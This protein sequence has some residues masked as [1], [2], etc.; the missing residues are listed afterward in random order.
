MRTDFR[1]W[2]YYYARFEN[3]T[4]TTTKITRDSQN[5]HQAIPFNLPSSSSHLSS[6]YPSISRHFQ[7]FLAIS[8]PVQPI[9]ALTSLLK[10]CAVIFFGHFKPFSAIS[11][12]L[13]LSLANSSPSQPFLKRHFHTFN[14][15]PNHF[16]PF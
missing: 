9:Q 12:H 6:P 13:W 8:I 5:C 10:P 15:I 4:Q 11:S 3:I 14:D 7:K 1:W 16:Q 2:H